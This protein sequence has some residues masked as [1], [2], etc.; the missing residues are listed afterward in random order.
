MK[1]RMQMYIE[2]V[3]THF[4]TKYPGVIYCWDVVN[5]A[6]A[7]NTGEF[8]S[9]DARH[10]RQVRDENTNLFYDHIG[11]DYVELAFKYAYE[12]RK[13]LQAANRQTAKPILSCSTTTTTPL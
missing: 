4:E 7:D 12:T 8:E 5:E 10:V 6:V 3:M 11:P 13:T 2:E 1:K 9:S